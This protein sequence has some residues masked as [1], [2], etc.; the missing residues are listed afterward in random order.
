MDPNH[1]Q[2][3]GIACTKLTQL[4]NVMVAV[5]STESP[6]LQQHNLAAQIS[7][8][9]RL[10]GI[11]PINLGRKLR[12]IDFAAVLLHDASPLLDRAS[13]KRTL[14][15]IAES[16]GWGEYNMGAEPG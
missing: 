2:L 16:M 10:L 7:H 5:N 14:R 11:Q 3:V 8:A 13:Q 12:G 6:K 9:Q 15:Y 1:N 4:R